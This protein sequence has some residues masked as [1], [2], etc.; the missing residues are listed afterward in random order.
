MKSEGIWQLCSR[1][2]LFFAG[3]LVMATSFPTLYDF[4]L[5][6]APDRPFVLYSPVTD[7]FFFSEHDDDG[8]PVY[9]DE[10]GNTYER[11]HYELLTPLFWYRDVFRWNQMPKTMDGVSVTYEKVASEYQILRFRAG[12]LKNARLDLWPLF[13]SASDFS[14]LTLPDEMFRKKESLVF[15]NGQTRQKDS[16]MTRKA[17]TVLAD[18]GFVFPVDGVWGQPTTRKDHDDG[19]FLTD[20][21]G[22]LYHLKKEKG[23]IR[24]QDTGIRPPSGIRYLSVEEDQRREFFGYYI[25]GDGTFHLILQKEYRDVTLPLPELNP[26]TMSVLLL[27]DLLG[28]TLTYGNEEI[29]YGVRVDRDYKSI[30]TFSRAIA[31]ALSPPLQMVK[32]ALFPFTIRTREVYSKRADL[33]VEHAGILSLIGIGLSVVLLLGIRKYRTGSW[34]ICAQEW[35]LLGL[36]GLY[37]FVMILIENGP[38]ERPLKP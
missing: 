22:R 12:D 26:D 20:G 19:Y 29:L 31:P 30:D 1:Y 18:A 13:E 23:V 9:R 28:T 3:V 27:S 2:L 4:A 10:Q 16:E 14:D 33:A 17:H 37:G 38:G 36:T 6:G 8:N 7:G 5:K 11:N 35:I 34:G 15:V 24:A 32:E 25:A 21:S